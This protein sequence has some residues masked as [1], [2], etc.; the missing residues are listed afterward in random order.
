MVGLVGLAERPVLWSALN[1]PST[2]GCPPSRVLVVMRP[3]SNEVVNPLRCPLFRCDAATV[4]GAASSGPQPQLKWERS[5]V[6][7][8]NS[9]TSVVS[10]DRMNRCEAR[11]QTDVR[12]RTV[13]LTDGGLTT[14][15]GRR[16]DHDP[17]FGVTALRRRLLHLLRAVL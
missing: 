17:L 4:P 13:D 10:A 14:G 7:F 1:V 16:R 2:T 11:H 3:G 12:Q 15:G 9:R 8:R 6:T 5:P